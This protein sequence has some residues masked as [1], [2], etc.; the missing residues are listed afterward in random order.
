[1]HFLGLARNYDRERSY[2][3]GK[4]SVRYYHADYL[5]PYLRHIIEKYRFR[6]IYFDDD[7]FNL[8][9]SHTVEMC[10]MMKRIGLPW[11]AMCR[12]DTIQMA[13]WSVMKESGCYGVK[14]GFESGNQYV[15][16]KIINKHLDLAYAESVVRRLRKLNMTVHGTFT[17]GLPGETPEQMRE[18]L[19]FVRSILTEFPSAFGHR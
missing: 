10:R 2:G 15:V 3:E 5:E 11:S 17:I 9:N 12:A 13:T 16:D 14:L 8:G 7:T 1:M 4:R 6:S 18:T 19:E